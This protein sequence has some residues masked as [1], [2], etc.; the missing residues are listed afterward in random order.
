MNK[1][2]RKMAGVLVM[3]GIFSFALIP[4]HA[5][6][7]PAY[8]THE[9]GR[10]TATVTITTEDTA[11][12]YPFE[13]E[14][15]L[16]GKTYVKRQDS[17]HREIVSQT[18]ITTTTR[19]TETTTLS[20]LKDQAVPDTHQ[21]IKDGQTFPLSL[22]S[23]EYQPQ[24]V[25]TGT[26]TITGQTVYGFQ[27]AQ[28]QAPETKMIPYTDGGEVKQAEG[29]FTG[30]TAGKNRWKSGYTLTAKFIGDTDVR[31]YLYGN[32]QMPNTGSVPPVKG[33]E[34]VILQG[35]SLD[36]KAVR[37]D[38]ATWQG[39]PVMENGQPVRYASLSC[40]R[41]GREYTASYTAVVPIQ[42]TR[43]TATAV[44]ENPDVSLPTG[45]NQYTINITAGY[46]LQPNLSPI[47]I[48]SIALLVAVLLTV[49]ILLFLRHKK[50]HR[51]DENRCPTVAP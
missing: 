37:I 46:D 49:V 38:S 2:H 34:A 51:K 25:Q 32:T 35:L 12:D 39:H 47:L 33:F 30:W 22:V 16:D 21:V 50:Q 43:Y 9:D 13:E 44:Y 20:E 27:T 40:S 14:I 45:Q 29:A 48:F 10:V 15:T 1:V 3:A 24:Q 17:V 18:P 36:P 26:R 4:V 7:S 5:D 19:L 28:P 31:Y 6:Q 42:E 11:Q 8:Q 23:A 41:L